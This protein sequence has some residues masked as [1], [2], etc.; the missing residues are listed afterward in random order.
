MK[1]IS[2]ALFLTAALSLGVSAYAQTNPTGQVDNPTGQAAPQKPAEL[3]DVPA[4]HWASAAIQVAANCGIVRGFPDGT[5]RGN[6]PITRYQAAVII[7]RLLEAIKNGEC[8]VGTPGG[9]SSADMTTLQNAIQELSADLAQLGVRVAELEDN[10]VTQDDL[11]RVEE[12]ATQ[13]RDLAEQ[14]VAAAGQP[15]TPAGE[16][17]DLSNYA[18]QDDLARVEEIANQARDLAEALAAGQT[19]TDQPV[20][21][22]TGVDPQA[23]ADLTDQ[24]EAASIAA[25]TA[26]AQARELQDKVDELSGRVDDLEG[27]LGELG[28]T[29]EGQADSIAALNDLV[30]L[31]NQDVLSLQD[32]V[33]ALEQSSGDLTQQLS[34]A[35]ATF[36]TQDDLESLREFTTLLRRDQT[37]LADRVGE[38]ENRVA[39]AENRITAVETR[40]TTLENNAFTISGTIGL[41]YQRR[42]TWDGAGGGNGVNFDV[43]RLFFG[44]P[45]STGEDADNTI[46]ADAVTDY[47]DFGL[48]SATDAA[49]GAAL[50]LQTSANTLTGIANI[51]VDRNNK[52]PAGTGVRWEGSINPSISLNFAFKPRALIG[53]TTNG[54]GNSFSV[55][56]NLAL[57]DNGTSFSAPSNG[58]SEITAT[59]FTLT[60]LKTQYTIGGAPLTFQYGID[61]AF[62]FTEYGFNNAGDNNGRGD[63]FVATLDGSGLL[64]L[65]LGLTIAYGSTNG[66]DG[67]NRYF[68]GIRGTASLIPGFTGGIYYGI[69]AADILAGPQATINLY[70]LNF[71]GS[72]GPISL[73]GEYNVSQAD[74]S[75]AQVAGFV[76]GSADLGFFTIAANY[77]VVDVAYTTARGI[78]VNFGPYDNNQVGF[79]AD[80]ALKLGFATVNFYYD[81][82]GTKDASSVLGD[83]PK[84]AT[85]SALADNEVD[86]GASFAIRLIGFDIAPFFT[87]ENETDI[88]GTAVFD[89]TNYGVRLTHDGSKPDALIRGFNLALGYLGRTN[90]LTGGTRTTLYA[91]ADTSISLAGFTIAP[92]AYFSQVSTSDAS[93]SPVSSG[94]AGDDVTNY[95]GALTISGGFLFGSTLSLSGALDQSSHSNNTGTPFTSS[96]GWISASLSFNPSIFG[97]PSTFKVAFASRTDV[98]RDGRGSGPTLASPLGDDSW[99]GGSDYANGLT[100]PGG[101]DAFAVGSNLSGLYFTFAYYGLTFDY[102]IFALTDFRFTSTAVGGV[103]FGQA[104]RIGYSLRF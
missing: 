81:Q 98:N 52:T 6:E 48:T 104:F 59:T 11:A 47:G 82:R 87:R 34:D 80:I 27:Q 24:V 57:V 23:I 100:P 5:F 101:R 66:R 2:A 17:V 74:G 53:S 43:D 85:D 56:L 84:D 86:F 39:A 16:P 58:G 55:S 3:S 61:P 68:T 10:A 40:V 97:T 91:Y 76:R 71:G 12:I 44:S 69:E 93:L 102:G 79:G 75:A 99:A 77:R 54:I 95:G 83:G 51:S 28:A 88:G 70:G 41:N 30:V 46:A 64:P 35:Q 42:I 1:K 14:A 22:Q 73:N 20:E 19:T 72:L 96:T 90:G 18:T 8:G 32:R 31:L 33:T 78:S 7:A 45:F 36:A 62:K 26:L 89:Q 50:G 13:A 15:T 49:D 60:S 94:I 29:V 25:D 65:N 63:G 37:A 38:L 92:K 67:D 21:N 9:M 103:T 4:G